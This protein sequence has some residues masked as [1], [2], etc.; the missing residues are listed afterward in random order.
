MK[1]EIIKVDPENIDMGQIEKA[2]NI[3]RNGG[4]V[5][6]PT[7]TVYGLGA[8]AYDGDAAKKIYEAKGRP[9][10]N[11]LIVHIADKADFETLCVIENRPLFERLTD[12]FCP[13]PLT[14]INKRRDIVPLSVTAGLDTVAVRFPAHPVARALIE[15]SGLPVAAPSANL[16]GKPSPT[17][18]SHVISDLDGRVDLIIDG[19]DCC[20]GLESTVILMKDGGIRLL[21]PGGITAEMLKGVY[22][23]TEIDPSVLTLLAQGQ[24][25]L[26]PG[27]KYRHYAP[28]A[29]LYAVSGEDESVLAFFDEKLREENTGVLCFDED[30]Y[31]LDKGKNKGR[32]ISLGKREDSREQAN[33]LFDCLR[34]FDRDSLDSIYTRL[35]EKDNLG[36]AVLNRLLKACGYTVI[37]L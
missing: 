25:P 32:L 31:I 14:I 13:G 24:E 17:R 22:P 36:L 3:I 1:T 11:P 15:A 33:R 19:G 7:E 6:F 18:A 2:A 8:N 35:P 4:L 37:Q 16:S 30:F 5:A 23:D 21:R 28:R 34:E 10:D 29:P 26:S 12:A 27:M 9:Q 20:L